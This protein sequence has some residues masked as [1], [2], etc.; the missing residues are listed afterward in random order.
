MFGDILGMMN[1]Y[2]E[3][4]IGKHE[5]DDF[6]VSTCEVTDSS[7]PFETAVCCKQLNDNRWIIVEMYDDTEEAELGHE[8]WIKHMQTTPRK[9]LKLKD[10]STCSIKQLFDME[11]EEYAYGDEK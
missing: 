5:E 11:D 6:T 1:N 10:V 2:E 7:Q 8:K 3:R 4:K 9:D